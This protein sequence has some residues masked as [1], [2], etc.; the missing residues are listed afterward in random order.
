MLFYQVS[1]NTPWLV[2]EPGCRKKK[3]RIFANG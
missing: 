2:T 1:D 3:K